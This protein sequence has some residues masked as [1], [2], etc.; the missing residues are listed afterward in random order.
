MTS[1]VV[2]YWFLNS[3]GVIYTSLV[4]LGVAGL[5][6]LY[7]CPAIYPE[8][9]GC[10]IPSCIATV[11]LVE[12]IVNLFLFHYNVGV[13][14]GLFHLQVVLEQTKSGQL[15]DSQVQLSVGRQ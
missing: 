3:A 7:T 14:W 2:F 9:G 12:L 15:L 13:L 5:N 4:V 1:S 11:I 8:P 10:F 6:L